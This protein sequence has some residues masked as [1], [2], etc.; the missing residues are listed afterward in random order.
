[1]N[2]PRYACITRG[3]FFYIIW[4]VHRQRYSEIAHV[5]HECVTFI[6]VTWLIHIC[7]MTHSY[8]WHDS[9]ICVTW[10]IHMCDM[11]YSYVWHDSFICVTCHIHMCD[12][13]HSYM[14]HDSFI[15]VT[16]LIHMCDMTYS[17]VWHDSFVY[18]T[19]LIHICDMTRM[20]LICVTHMNSS[21]V[22]E[23]TIQ[24]KKPWYL[25]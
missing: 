14:W 12:M 8:V 17:Y 18:V 4:S 22:Y 9:F 10:L 6:C 11:T 5:V 3:I 24:K 7:D 21:F 2:A 1:M 16:W 13:T 25:T 20:A 15:C 19:W 23:G